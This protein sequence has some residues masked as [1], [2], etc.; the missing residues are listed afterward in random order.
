MECII[1]VDLENIIIIMSYVVLPAVVKTMKNNSRESTK[2]SISL[3][4]VSSKLIIGIGRQ[5]YA[6]ATYVTQ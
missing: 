2:C 3:L 4:L 5:R 6:A 1:I